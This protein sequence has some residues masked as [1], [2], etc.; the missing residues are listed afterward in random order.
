MSASSTTTPAQE[1]TGA[2][3]SRPVASDP[4]S[5]AYG[6]TR[7]Q[8]KGTRSALAN[9][10]IGSLSRSGKWSVWLTLEPRLAGF[11]SLE[12]ALEGWRRRDERCYQVVA[13]LTALGSRR[14]GD[15]DDAA[16]AVVVLLEDGVIRVATTLNDL[17]EVDDVN[18]TVW[19]EVKA[20]E[21]Q[22]GPHAAR[23]LLQRSRQRLSRPAAGMVSRVET[24]SL[25]QRIQTN[26]ALAVGTHSD[27]A[28]REDQDRDLLL[29]VPDVEDPVEDLADLLT[30]ATGVGV[31]A[32]EEVDLI[33]E[34]LAAE[35]DGMA[36][37]EAQSLVGERHGVA[38]RTIRRRRD[39][40]AARL[41]EAAP[42][43]L[44]AIA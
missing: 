40:T 14:G 12:E 42:K 16:L 8:S 31:I 1:V 32:T 27:G 3:T 11:D 36:R 39:A 7:R 4:F 15:D 21:P 26:N 10:V 29:A 20:A 38:M 19:E 24:T 23:Y 9:S 22:L 17:C 35:N 30:W 13:G 41:R 18:A 5:S 25:E 33:V 43:Y 37:E 28:G 34:L 44:A 6:R 2:T